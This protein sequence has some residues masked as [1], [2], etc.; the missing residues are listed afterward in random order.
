MT[1]EDPEPAPAPVVAVAAAA[2]APPAN[3]RSSQIQKAVRHAAVVAAFAPQD[4]KGYFD[5]AEQQVALEARS[6]PSTPLPSPIPTTWR[7]RR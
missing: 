2:F 3:P 5:L 6:R 4:P 1:F 7:A